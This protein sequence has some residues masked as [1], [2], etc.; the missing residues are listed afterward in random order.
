MVL[1]SHLKSAWSRSLAL[2]FLL[3]SGAISIAAPSFAQVP[4]MSSIPAPAVSMT[5]SIPLEQTTWQLVSYRD[6]EGDMVPAWEERPATF[7][8]QAGRLTGTTGC[9]RF[10]NAYTLAGDRLT[11]EPGGSTLMACFPEA[12]AQQETAILSG[13]TEVVNHELVAEELRLLNGEGDAVLILTP[14]I[15]APLTQTEWQLTAYNNGRGG[16]VTPLIDTAITATFSDDGELSGS[17]SCNRYR[18]RFVQTNHTLNIEAA[19]TTRRLC[20]TPDGVMQQEQAFLAVLSEVE[21]YVIEGNQL[22]LQNAAG[23]TLAEFVV[24]E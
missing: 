3:G 15:S 2:A 18:A 10:F 7:Q 19:A 22:L 21:T 5:T 13:L 4:T 23:T 20:A 6:A 16:L 14:Q 8:F 9:N 1:K 17:A 11:L 24:A 12:I